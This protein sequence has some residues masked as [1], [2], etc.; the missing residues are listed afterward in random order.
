MGGNLTDAVYATPVVEGKVIWIKPS[1][2]LARAHRENRGQTMTGE[3][4]VAFVE[5]KRRSQAW[6][7]AKS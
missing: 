2:A 4:A 6:R 7:Y 3:E 1:P 5:A